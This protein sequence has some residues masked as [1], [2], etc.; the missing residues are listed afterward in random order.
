MH[1][2]N[3]APSGFC[4]RVVLSCLDPAGPSQDGEQVAGPLL[5]AHP[6]GLFI[7]FP[8]EKATGDWWATYDSPKDQEHGDRDPCLGILIWKAGSGVPDLCAQ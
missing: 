1:F 3:C 2:T 4:P 8:R 6:A 5:G 7:S